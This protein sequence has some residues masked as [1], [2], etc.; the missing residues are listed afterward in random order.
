MTTDP[1][2]WSCDTGQWIPCFG[3]CP[4]I[5]TW[6][7]NIRLQA[8]T[9]ARKCEISHQFPCGADGWVDRQMDVQ[10]HNYMYQN[11][12]NNP[13]FLATVCN[14]ALLGL[15]KCVHGASLKLM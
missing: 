13:I 1:M 11:S 14:G 10:S 12:S 6:M 9:L 7:H 3:S 8:P 4:L 5:T 15:A 2:T